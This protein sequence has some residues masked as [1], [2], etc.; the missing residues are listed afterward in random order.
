MLTNNPSHNIHCM[1]CKQKQP[2][3]NAEIVTMKN[4][5][6]RIKGECSICGT[7]VSKILGKT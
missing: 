1:K 4:G 3:N 6:K 5:R 2:T 7:K